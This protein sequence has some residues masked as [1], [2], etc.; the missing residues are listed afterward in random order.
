MCIITC[1][2][3]RDKSIAMN[4]WRKWFVNH[5]MPRNGAKETEPV[6]PMITNCLAL[7]T[8]RPNSD[9][10]ISEYYGSWKPSLD[11]YYQ[12]SLEMDIRWVDAGWYWVII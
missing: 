1:D 7:D 12:E 5:V 11:K 4:H 3:N 6:R 8:G 9:G 10:S 2:A